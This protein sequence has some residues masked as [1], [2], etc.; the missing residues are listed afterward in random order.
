ML[1]SRTAGAVLIAV[2]IDAA[3]QQT[4]GEL[5]DDTVLHDVQLS[6]NSRDLSILR[7]RF[8]E[9][10]YLPADIVIDGTRMRNVAVRVRGTASRNPTKLGL[11]VDFSFYTRGQRFR[12]LE[13]IVLDN[14]YQDPSNIRE[15]LAMNVFR[16]LGEPAPREAFCRMFINNQYQG[17]YGLVEEIVPDFATRVTG[18]DDGYLFEYHNSFLYRGEDLGPGFDL[19]K[20]LFEPRSHELDTDDQLY[21]PIRD[22]FHDMNDPDDA[23]WL[24][25]VAPR[26][27]LPQFMRSVGIEA[28]LAEKDGVLGFFGMNNFYLYRPAVTGQQRIFVWD[29]DFAMSFFDLSV[30]RGLDDYA[31]FRRAFANADLRTV[32]LDAAENVAR[33]I[34]DNGWLEGEIDRLAALIDTAVRDDTRKPFTNEFF[35]QEIAFLRE[36]ARFRPAFL[37]DEIARVR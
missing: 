22:L 16:R 11:R 20:M 25:R 15:M 35:D 8:G 10:I 19:Y 31:F 29:R 5:F 32:Y 6:I 14:L 17:L 13:S 7:Q 27:D 30:V 28:A 18:E 23:V 1:L 2:A 4:G 33:M 37:V 12:G 3:P 21:G 34:A 26:L 24:E 36:F 9:N